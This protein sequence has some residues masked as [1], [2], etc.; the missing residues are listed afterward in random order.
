[1]TEDEVAQ[2]KDIAKYAAM[3]EGW[4]ATR[5]EFDRALLTL[6]GGGVGLLAAFLTRESSAPTTCAQL[7]LYGI[8]IL[9]FVVAMG[10]LLGTF[11]RNTSAFEDAIRGGTGADPR[12]AKLHWA[13]VIAFGIGVLIT[14]ILA[15]A[16]ATTR[17]EDMDRKTNTVTTV[18]PPAETTVAPPASERLGVQNVGKALDPGRPVATS[19][20]A[21]APA[22]ESGTQQPSSEAPA[23]VPAASGQP[24]A[25]AAATE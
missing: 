12:L 1:L 4:I 22:Q 5:M 10:A 18:A 19:P 20:A 3:A 21:T 14:I 23:A 24:A 11:A 15:F 6:S 8:G 7:L 16:T 9:S 17:G 2:H 25:P 13:A